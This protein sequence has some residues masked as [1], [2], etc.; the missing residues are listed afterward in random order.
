[1]GSESKPGKSKSRE[2]EWLQDQELVGKNEHHLGV[3]I[4]CGKSI[5]IVL[6]EDVGKQPEEDSLVELL[7]SGCMVIVQDKDNQG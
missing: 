4:A 2:V 1:M 6:A 3:L 5:V 7:S